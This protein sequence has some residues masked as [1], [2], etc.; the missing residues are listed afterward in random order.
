[1][2]PKFI[3]VGPEKAIVLLKY[4]FHFELGLLS[5]DLFTCFLMLSRIVSLVIM[6]C[7]FQFTFG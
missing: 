4:C 1:M 6:S 3:F 2:L 7:C 5:S